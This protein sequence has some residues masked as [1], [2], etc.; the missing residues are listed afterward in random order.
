MHA[1]SAE[2]S[3]NTLHAVLAQVLAL[4]R[5]SFRWR[6][7][8]ISSP[9]IFLRSW[10]ETKPFRPN[11]KMPGQPDMPRGPAPTIFSGDPTRARSGANGPRPRGKSVYGPAGNWPY[12]PPVRF[13]KSAD[14]RP[15]MAAHNIRATCAPQTPYLR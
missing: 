2:A 11:V 9:Y 7:R 5:L 15:R 6:P 12:A 8:V 3:G 4:T 13:R 1:S 10:M 14:S